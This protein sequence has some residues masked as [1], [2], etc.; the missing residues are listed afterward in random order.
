MVHMVVVAMMPAEWGWVDLV[1]G[2]CDRQ[3]VRVL[4]LHGEEPSTELWACRPTVG[5]AVPREWFRY[6]YDDASGQW[7]WG[8]GTGTA[9]PWWD[10]HG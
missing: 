3:R 2:P 6:V 5:V 7:R 8:G 4:P 1:G 9:A 10:W